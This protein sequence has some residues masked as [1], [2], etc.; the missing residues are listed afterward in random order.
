[1]PRNLN[2]FGQAC[3]VDHWS[4]CPHKT[5]REFVVLVWDPW[6]IISLY[7]LSLN[8]LLRSYHKEEK[9]FQPFCQP[10]TMDQPQ[11]LTTSDGNYNHDGTD[12]TIISYILQAAIDCHKVIR[13]GKLILLHGMDKKQ[14]SLWLKT[15]LLYTHKHGKPPKVM[16]L[17]PTSQHLLLHILRASHV[18]ML[19]KAADQQSSP[20]LEFAKFGREIQTAGP[21]ELIQIIAFNSIATAQ[22]CS[23]TKLHL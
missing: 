1:M 15:Y 2:Y 10:L 6:T 5:V 7:A 23:T 13:L 12:I 8:S 21:P 18:V 22:S 19:G 3:C 9:R 17:P 11:L 14:G 4:H 16:S 20:H